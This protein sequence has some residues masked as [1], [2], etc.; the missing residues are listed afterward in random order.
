M[1]TRNIII[2]NIF[3]NVGIEETTFHHSDE[4]CD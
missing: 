4:L 3:V 1:K 2:T